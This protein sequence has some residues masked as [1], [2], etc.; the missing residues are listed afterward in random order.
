VKDGRSLAM[1]WVDKIDVK[2][3]PG[4]NSDPKKLE[5]TWQPL[6]IADYEF[7]F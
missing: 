1:N 6:N 7:T 2:V 5:F 3:L 4:P